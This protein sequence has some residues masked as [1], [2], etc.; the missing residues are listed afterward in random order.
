MNDP[1]VNFLGFCLSHVFQPGLKENIIN[2]TMHR[3]EHKELQKKSSL[4]DP[5]SRNEGCPRVKTVEEISFEKYS[6]QKVGWNLNLTG[7]A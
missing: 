2:R 6:P 5:K 1:Q 4:S 7:L 3:Y